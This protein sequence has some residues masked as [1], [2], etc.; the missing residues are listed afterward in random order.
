M[1]NISDLQDN[2]HQF[3]SPKDYIYKYREAHID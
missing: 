1:Q 3:I 2:K